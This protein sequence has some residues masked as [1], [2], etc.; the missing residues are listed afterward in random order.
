MSLFDWPALVI[1]FLAAAAGGYKPL[2]GGERTRSL[3]GFPR[4]QAFSAGVFLALSLII[5]LPNGAHLFSKVLPHIHYPLASAT[6]LCAFLILLTFGHVASARGSEDE[7]DYAAGPAL[8]PIIMTVMI[9]IPS[10][11]LGAALGVSDHSMALIIFL[12]V[13]IHKSS[14]GFALGLAMVRSSLSR[15]GSIA[16]FGLF[17][18][19]TPLGII[20]GADLHAYL[21]TDIA[22]V[23]KAVTLSLASGVF[24]F[25]GTLHEMKHAPLIIHCCATRGFLAMLAGLLLTA[26]VRVLVGMAHTGHAG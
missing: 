21:T 2:T 16:L 26:F 10:F 19:A 25:M 5:M 23:L 13:L 24:L 1:I 7:G 20:L 3:T 22:L 8:V 6:A 14:A 17:A 11:L 18:C 9:T 4:G 15:G 12:A